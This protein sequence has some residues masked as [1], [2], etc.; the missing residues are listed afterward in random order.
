MWQLSDIIKALTQ[1]HF[2][3][4]FG[5]CKRGSNR[6]GHWHDG[7]GKRGK[8]RQGREREI[9]RL[10]QRRNKSSHWIDWNSIEICF[11]NWTAL[12]Q[13][14]KWH[15]IGISYIDARAITLFRGYAK[16]VTHMTTKYDISYTF[17]VVTF[18]VLDKTSSVWC[19]AH[20]RFTT[21]IRLLWYC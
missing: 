5:N 8:V 6:M 21:L 19:S 13:A 2:N 9:A 1:I 20:Y 4:M 18:T 12:I 10:R 17:S 15:W 7:Q 11:V 14:L 16:Y 3:V